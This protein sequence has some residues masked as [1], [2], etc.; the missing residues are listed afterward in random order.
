MYVAICKLALRIF[1][2]QSLKGKRRVVHSI[3]ERINNRFGISIAEV[4]NVNKWQIAELGFALVGSEFRYV[5]DQIYSIVDYVME[6][7]FEIE[8][9]DKQIEIMPFGN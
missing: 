9:T 4:N 6:C 8:I 2:S 5:N 7:S 1:D 3:K